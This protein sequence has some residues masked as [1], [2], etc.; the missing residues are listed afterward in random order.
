[1]DPSVKMD[2][3]KLEEEAN[4]DQN[5]VIDDDQDEEKVMRHFKTIKFSMI[6]MITD[7]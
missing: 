2:E 3:E 5:E 1:M 7:L 6:I 4:T